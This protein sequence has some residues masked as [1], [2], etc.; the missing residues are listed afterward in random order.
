[1]LGVL[2]EGGWLLA[3]PGTSD[4]APCSSPALAFLLV[5]Y[6]LESFSQRPPNNF[7]LDVQISLISV[8]LGDEASCQPLAASAFR[9]R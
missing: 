9:K 1:M 7:H 3:R 2:G 5:S 4:D 8:S 6:K